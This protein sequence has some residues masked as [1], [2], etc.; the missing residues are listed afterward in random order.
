MPIL[1]YS[2][3]LSDFITSIYCFAYCSI[4]LRRAFIPLTIDDSLALLLLMTWYRSMKSLILTPKN[5]WNSGSGRPFEEKRG[6]KG[7]KFK[8]RQER[9]RIT[10]WF[11]QGWSYNVHEI[12][13]HWVSSATHQSWFM[14]ANKVLKLRNWVFDNLSWSFLIN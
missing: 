5:L 10:Y 1:L 2:I 11:Q 13:L 14:L 6:D 8:I 12:T 9:S 4:G 3:R 7:R